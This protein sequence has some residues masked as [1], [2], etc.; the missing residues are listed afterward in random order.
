MEPFSMATMVLEEQHQI[1][2]P[3]LAKFRDA[4]DHLSCSKRDRIFI[5][6]MYLTGARCSELV[7]RVVPWEI[8]HSSTKPYGTLLNWE[9]TN[10]K[11]SDGD[12]VKILLLKL[13][14]AK[15]KV[16]KEEDVRPS[17]NTT[18]VCQ[19]LR[20]LSES[21]MF[22]SLVILQLSLGVVSYSIGSQRTKS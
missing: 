5:I 19:T 7:T 12:I 10:Y 11:K 22:Q 1:R 9:L 13:G 17:Q 20:H 4:V 21:D 18:E 3:S 8:N 2:V 16:K 14:V 15:H 6:V